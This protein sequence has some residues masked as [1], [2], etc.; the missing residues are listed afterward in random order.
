MAQAG[1]G[2]DTTKGFAQLMG[3]DPAS[4]PAL[5]LATA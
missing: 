2:G 3:D 1:A 4:G 5:P